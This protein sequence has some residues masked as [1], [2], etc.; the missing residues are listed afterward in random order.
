ML[1]AGCYGS[2]QIGAI[3]ENFENRFATLYFDLPPYDADFCWGVLGPINMSQ[4]GD[5]GSKEI[6]DWA[7]IH[8]T[9]GSK[10]TAD[11]NKLERK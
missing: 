10:N 5:S 2:F 9:L 1:S 4:L 8:C 11:S 3:R 7:R 6:S